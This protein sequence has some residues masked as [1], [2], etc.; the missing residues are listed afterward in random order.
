MIQFFFIE[1]R[2]E[3]DLYAHILNLLREWTAF[4]FDIQISQIQR[5]YHILCQC[6]QFYSFNGVK[7]RR[8]YDKSKFW[9]E[10]SGF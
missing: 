3:V 10:K 9:S 7:V 6:L 8:Y 5:I 1:I 4:E 2:R